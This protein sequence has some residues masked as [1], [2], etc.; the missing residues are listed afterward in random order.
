MQEYN[1]YEQDLLP[2]R[3]LSVINNW[4]WDKNVF[5]QKDNYHQGLIP[6]YFDAPMPERS[7]VMNGPMGDTLKVLASDLVVEDKGGGANLIYQ[8]LTTKIGRQQLVGGL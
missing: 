2:L 7:F 5:F 8:M 6:S 3:K 1:A 4:R